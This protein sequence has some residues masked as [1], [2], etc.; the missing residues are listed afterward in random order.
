MQEG[1]RLKETF[2]TLIAT[3]AIKDQSTSRNAMSDQFDF[4]FSPIEENPLDDMNSRFVRFH[5]NNPHVYKNLVVLARKFRE[6]R[7]DAIVGIGMLY[8]VLRWKYYMTTE[9]EDEY[10][11]SNDF[12]AAYSRLIM[13]QESDLKGIFKCKKSAYDENI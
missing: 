8:E 11:L 9:T 3:Q 7:P 6:K 5:D 2:P 1:N 12:R 10:K 4:D 13:K